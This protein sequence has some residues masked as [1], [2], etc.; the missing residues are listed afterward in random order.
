MAEG[1]L[2]A[3]V[4]SLS[5]RRA[6]ALAASLVFLERNQ[7]RAAGELDGSLPSWGLSAAA[8]ASWE[9]TLCRSRGWVPAATVRELPAGGAG[10]ALPFLS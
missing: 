1:L 7:E 6:A 4:A 3:W 2:R 9:R 8:T 10:G 5:V